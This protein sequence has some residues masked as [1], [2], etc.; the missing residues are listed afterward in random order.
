M[1]RYG[2]NPT[3][4]LNLAEASVVKTCRTRATLGIY[5]ASIAILATGLL[6]G[7]AKNNVSGPYAKPLPLGQNCKSVRSELRRMDSQGIPSYVEAV[8]AGRKVSKSGREKASR[9]NKLLN[10]YLSARCHA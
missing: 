2:E 8:N 1:G 7:C 9:Y 5:H 3:E 6:A 10:D 4:A